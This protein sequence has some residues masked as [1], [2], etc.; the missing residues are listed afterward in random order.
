SYST[1]FDHLAFNAA[2]DRALLQTG[3]DDNRL[4]LIN[5]LNE[6]ANK[7]AT[8]T[9]EIDALKEQILRQY[10][11]DKEENIRIDARF[12][13]LVQYYSNDLDPSEF[14]EVRTAVSSAAPASA[15]ADGVAVLPCE[16][17]E[18]LQE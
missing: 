1:E 5:G 13:G 12:S 8:H 10:E 18:C 6:L 4:A 14:V 16:A 11:T 9:A 2:V 15:G 3:L 7:T 17:A